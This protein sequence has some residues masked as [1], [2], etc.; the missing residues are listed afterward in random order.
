MVREQNLDLTSTFRK[1]WVLIMMVL[2]NVDFIM[3]PFR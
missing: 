3:N 2:L 1:L